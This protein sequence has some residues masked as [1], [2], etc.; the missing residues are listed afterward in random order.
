MATDNKSLGKFILDGIPSAPRGVPQIEVTF[1][2]DANGILNVTAQDKATSR[3]QHITIT[4]S[5]G[6]SEAE[7]QRMKEE[8]GAHVEE[9]KK[10]QELVEAKNIADSTVYSA[11]KMLREFGEKIPADLKTTLEDNT[12]QLR[13]DFIGND[14][15]AIRKSTEVLQQAI[16][17]V[18]AS[19]YQQPDGAAKPTASN[20]DPN[21]AQTGPLGGDTPD[22]NP[23]D[24]VDG[25]FK[26][27]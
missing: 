4:A 18:G 26:N 8:A 10:R 15:D 6:L 2:I 21:S 17:K 22:E 19:M 24:V 11:E 1:D 14:M 13:K 27:L 7:V 5:S 3:S 12:A 16:Q 20:S 25:E 23:G 9:D